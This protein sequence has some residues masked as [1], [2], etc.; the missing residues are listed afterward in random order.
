MLLRRFLLACSVSLGLVL[1]SVAGC[2]GEGGT[3]IPE[4]GS[5]SDPLKEA[6]APKDSA[7][8]KNTPDPSRK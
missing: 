6:P 7:P 5:A 8:P 2:G 4:P 3:S 1:L